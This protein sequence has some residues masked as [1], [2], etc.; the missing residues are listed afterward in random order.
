MLVVNCVLEDVRFQFLVLC[1][2]DLG[3]FLRLL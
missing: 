1:R 3:G 2:V